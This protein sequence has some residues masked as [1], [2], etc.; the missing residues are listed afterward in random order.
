MFCVLAASCLFTLFSFLRFSL[1]LGI[2]E[3]PLVQGLV[4]GLLTG[5]VTLAVS[6]ALVFELFWLDLIPAGT[7]IPPNAAAGN[8]AAQCLVTVFGFSDPARIVFPILL[9]LPL[10]WIASRLEQTHRHWQDHGYNV[11][12][13]WLRLD[14]KADYTPGLLLRRAMIQAA[15]VYFLFFLLA[16]SLLVALTSWLLGHGLLHPPLDMFS[17]GHLW[18]GATL[19]GLLALRV[20]GSYALLAL[21]ACGVAVLSLFT[22]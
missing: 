3:R 15:S 4:W 20:P 11:L 2:V 6:V 1:N 14:S 13:G 12:Q 5:N 18:I 21:G 17:W 22:G 10:A 19:G 7:F 16:V 8:L 9:A